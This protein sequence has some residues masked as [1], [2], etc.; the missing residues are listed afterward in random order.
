M[1]LA[2]HG[3]KCPQLGILAAQTE[4]GHDNRIYT[5]TQDVYV[6]GLWLAAEASWTHRRLLHGA[7]DRRDWT[8]M[9][10]SLFPKSGHV[11]P[12]WIGQVR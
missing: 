11:Q 10:F 7:P 3:F 9:T 2:R 5:C 12:L 8:V 1:G 4:H 6:D